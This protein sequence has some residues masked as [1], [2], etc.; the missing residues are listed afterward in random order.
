MEELKRLLLQTD[1]EYLIG[2]SNKGTV[3]RAYKDLE[4]E[5]PS[6]TWDGEEAEASWKEAVCRIRAPFGD[7]TCSCPSRSVCRHLIAAILYL[8]RAAEDENRK[9]AEAAGR[10]E[11]PDGK[12]KPD[13]GGATG[14][15]VDGQPEQQQA[16]NGPEHGGRLEP[17]FEQEL[18]KVPLKKLKQA[19]RTRG[20]REFLAH[21]EAGE[22][23]EI[24]EGTSGRLLT[25]RFPWNQRTVKLLS[26]LEHSTC[27]CHSR[28]LCVHKAQAVLAFQLQKGA[29]SLEQLKSE[30]EGEEVWNREELL[31]AARSIRDGIRL[32]LLTG[33]SRL[34]PE[35]SESMERLAVIS[36]G[37]GLAD[38]EAEFRSAQTEIQQYFQRSA[39]FRTE[40]LLDRLLR[41]Y[42]RALKLEHT[43]K[44]EELRALAGNFRDAYQPAG[45]LHLTA[46]GAESFQ[47][48]TGYAGE[49]YYFLETE[50]R[51]WYTW[52][53]ARPVFYEGVRRRPAGN[54]ER[55]QAPWGLGCSR[56]GMMELEFYLNQARAAEDGRL[57]VSKETT[58]EAVGQRNLAREEI[59]DMVVWDYRRLPA[60]LEA[61]LLPEAGGNL[62]GQ[63]LA[64]R[65]SLVL[66]GA[67]RCGEGHFD[68][69]QQRFSMEIF[70]LEG[71]KISVSVRY[72]EQEKLTLRVLERLSARLAARKQKEAPLV[73]FG[74][75]YLEGGRLCLYPIEYFEWEKFLPLQENSGQ[76]KEKRTDT[77]AVRKNGTETAVG[78]SSSGNGKAL[79]LETA[80][81]LE[82]Q[83]LEMRQA[84][85]DLFQSGLYSVQEE[86][87][88]ELLR[89][90]REE[91]ELG[92]H[93]G[94]EKLCALRKALEEKRHQMRF[95]PEPALEAWGWLME[96]TKI[97]LEKLSLDQALLRME[98]EK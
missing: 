15:N 65:E 57:S 50:Q 22:L 35:A 29:V 79:P 33:L 12:E 91:E 58:G 47:S 6:V 7:S 8:K 84:L 28:E 38:F 4:Q 46:I 27:T 17:A 97:C 13:R 77:G 52:T 94:S 14:E 63:E 21:A 40:G 26:P 39:A 64:V 1:E 76:T 34:S 74:A 48:K 42:R 55:E 72:S 41:L 92:L 86:S 61:K 20:Y 2:L 19:C 82:Q 90:E 73:F 51:R 49:R 16:Q 75:L 30:N 36:H 70:D 37:A 31:E 18:F 68:T 24:E 83:L 80:E 81:E 67:V 95:D 66:A 93:G 88:S 69:V 98:A 11:N 44:A 59:R 71:R 10:K 56:A 45:R 54:Y 78:Q 43:E 3:K 60:A 9:S 96:Y 25:V 32:M 53:D 23:P 62:P 5:A 85:A 87:L 89:L